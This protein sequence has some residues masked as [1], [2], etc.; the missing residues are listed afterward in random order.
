MKNNQITTNISREQSSE[1]EVRGDSKNVLPRYSPQ[2][3]AQ[4]IDAFQ[5]LIKVRDRCRAQGLIDW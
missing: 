2:E 4:A 5:L 3:V 1:I